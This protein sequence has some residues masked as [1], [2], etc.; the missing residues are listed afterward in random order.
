MCQD[1]TE[2][3]KICDT[4]PLN[5]TEVRAWNLRPRSKDLEIGPTVRFK[6]KV[7]MERIYDQLTSQVSPTFIDKAVSNK[8]AHDQISGFVK[9]GD[10]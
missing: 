6:P 2:N 3:N 7:Q 10:R 9:S 4:Q 1:A 8:P 5:I